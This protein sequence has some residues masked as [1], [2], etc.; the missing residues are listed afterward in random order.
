MS[1]ASKVGESFTEEGKASSKLGDLTMQLHS[2]SESSPASAKRKKDKKN[3]ISDDL[4]VM[5]KQTLIHI[6]TQLKRKADNA[7]R[8]EVP[9]EE[10]VATKTEAQ[11]SVEQ[12]ATEPEA[13]KKLKSANA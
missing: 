7:A 2:E 3:K 11:K 8:S 1:S 4:D 10:K 13:K 6:K 5:R 9:V 12:A